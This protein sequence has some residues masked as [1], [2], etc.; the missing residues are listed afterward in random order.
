LRSL[1]EKVDSKSSDGERVYSDT[2]LRAAM[3]KAMEEGDSHLMWEIMNYKTER[4]KKELRGEYEGEIKAQQER[5]QQ[6]KTEWATICQ[7]Y[8]YLADP[9]EDE[10]WA[11]SHAELDIKNEASTLYKLAHYMY[12]VEPQ[13]HRPGGSELVVAH[14]LARII[15]KRRGAKAPDKEKTRLKKQLV[16]ERRKKSLGTGSSAE[17]DTDVPV[18]PKSEKDKLDEYLAGRRK[19]QQKW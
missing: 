10:L 16:K 14:A 6:A 12:G 9:E 15:K 8:E 17:K 4:V 18:R 7:S 3:Q 11:G 5:A 1:K 13:Y 2:E 19:M